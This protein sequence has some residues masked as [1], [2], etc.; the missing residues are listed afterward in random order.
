MHIP[1]KQEV[2]DARH[3]AGL[4]QTAAAA[5]IHKKLR[6]WQQWE[7]GEAPMDPAYWELFRLKTS[8]KSKRS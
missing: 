4:S 7:Y 3:D 1:T 6:A 5:V 2:I 8:G